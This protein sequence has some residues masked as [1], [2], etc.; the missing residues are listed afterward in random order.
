[1]YV[2]RIGTLVWKPYFQENKNFLMKTNQ[3]KPFINRVLDKF[4]V[5]A[6]KGTEVM[7]LQPG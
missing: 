2:P 6:I 3:I 7:N 4:V 1:M 5:K